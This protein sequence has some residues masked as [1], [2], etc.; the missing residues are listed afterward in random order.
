MLLIPCYFQ[1]ICELFINFFYLVKRIIASNL[2]HTQ[3]T[4]Y[5]SICPSLSLNHHH[6]S[7]IISL[8]PKQ[9]LEFTFVPLQSNLN[10]VARGIL[11][12]HITSLLEPNTGFPHT[13]MKSEA[14]VVIH[15]ALQGLTANSLA[16]SPIFFFLMVTQRL[17]CCPH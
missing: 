16:S 17:P 12:Y 15:N 14:L 8:P 1:Q 13:Q 5:P 6:I 7:P 2:I 3:T 10:P 4:Y 9:P 11:S